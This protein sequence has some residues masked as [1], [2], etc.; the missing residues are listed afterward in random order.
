MKTRAT[1]MEAIPESFGVPPVQSFINKPT[2][3][4][5][6][7]SALTDT[8][9]PMPATETVRL[10]ETEDGAPEVPEEAFYEA[11]EAVGGDA[12]LRGPFT[13]GAS[14]APHRAKSD[15]QKPTEAV[16]TLLLE[17][18]MQ[19]FPHEYLLHVR[20]WLPLRHTDGRLEGTHPEVRFFVS[21]ERV[22]C[23][24]MR[25]DEMNTPGETQ[26][27]AVQ[28]G[29]ERV[30]EDGDELLSC[31]QTVALEMGKPENKWESF[32]TDHDPVSSWAVDFVQDRN[33]DWW[34][35]DMAIDAIYDTE[36][37]G[38]GGHG[39]TNTAAHPADGCPFEFNESC[40]R[41]PDDDELD[42]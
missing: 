19:R 21:D 28:A 37:G 7:Y 23:W 15:A 12:F 6:W 27:P 38:R 32:V 20:E 42:E 35:T 3:L 1:R 17:H 33:G 29:Q 11:L 16:S 22:N 18:V 39:F 30:K 8:D 24:H 2:A 5:T 36:E 9:V 34:L 41:F 10:E 4:P 31:A 13:A 26:P 25:M 40:W 14:G